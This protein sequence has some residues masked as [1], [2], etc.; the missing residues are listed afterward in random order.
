MYELDKH[1]RGRVIGGLRLEPHKAQSTRQPMKV[2]PVPARV[3]V[4]VRQ[5]AGEP[6]EVIVKPGDHVYKGQVIAR[7][8]G[9][10]GVPVHASI[11]GTVVDLEEQPVPHPSGLTELCVVIDSDGRD[12]WTPNLP[13]PIDDYTEHQPAILRNR[14][15][16]CGIVGMGGAAFPTAVKLNPPPQRRIHTLILNGVE[17]EPY[18][19]C[20]DMLMRERSE[21]ILAG[22]RIARYMLE[23]PLCIIGIEDD[24]PTAIEAMIKALGGK[25]VDGIRIVN[26]PTIYPAGG[27]RQLIQFITGKEVPHDGLPA[28]IGIMCH[29]VA[30]AYAVYRAV[31]YGESL[32]S[33][34]VTVTGPGISRSMNVEARIG[35]SV[36]E[37]IGAC[38]GYREDV[39]GLIM[40]GPM[41]GFAMNSDEVPVIK[42]TNCLL[43]TSQKESAEPGQIMPCIRCGECAR[44][45]PAS[46]LPQ[47]LYWHAQAKNLDQAQE[48]NLFACIECGCCAYVCPSNIPLVHYF[49]FAKSA[50]WSREQE[51]QAAE[52]ARRRFESREKRLEEAKRARA[53]RLAKK[54]A[55]L[56][57]VNVADKDAKQAVINASVERVKARRSAA[58]SQRDTLK[59][60]TS[61]GSRPE[62]KSNPNPVHESIT[63]ADR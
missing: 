4:P 9:Y 47:Q 48:Y 61:M 14:V 5:H 37:V 57:Q 41:M 62:N 2:L 25:E 50:I 51:K 26:V 7:A 42:A 39:T 49:R 12:E 19:T 52:L 36:N 16:E 30:T 24:M 34:I 8:T 10:I 60:V 29:N 21:E 46:L 23:N 1:K 27:E 15:R 28:D 32:I 35:T 63:T 44:V 31:R 38:G 33:R 20:D 45:C 56:A 13:E 3:V 18:I 59:G 55:A 17:C 53:E 6:A 54:K 58:Q 43:S 40:G 22:L 11:S